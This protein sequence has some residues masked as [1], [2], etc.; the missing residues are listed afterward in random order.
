METIFLRKS[1]KWNIKC[2]P[3][4]I[5][6]PNTLGAAFPAWVL[7]SGMFFILRCIGCQYHL[8]TQIY[9]IFS[10]HSYPNHI[11]VNIRLYTFLLFTLK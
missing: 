10:H 7:F 6:L 2:V 9:F 3:R 1:S 5:L 11:P 8:S 4:H